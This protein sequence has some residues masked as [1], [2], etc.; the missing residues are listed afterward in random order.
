MS[1]RQL[2]LPPVNA[3]VVFEAAAR[4]LSFTA[5]AA[6]LGVSQAAVS[7]QIRA[8]ED[9][10]GVALFR[11][12]HRAV[13]LT[14]EGERLFGAVTMGLG[15]ISETAAALR[16]DQGR[17]QITV[18]T[19]IAFAAFWLMPRIDRFKS[20]HPDLEL[21]FIAS[22]T[23]VD[24]RAEGIDIAVR[25]GAG[26]WPGLDAYRLFDEEVFP[27]CNPA[28]LEGGPR[29]DE[30]GDLLDATLLHQ[31]AGEPSWLTWRDWL[32][33]QDVTPPVKIPG[34]RFNN[35]TILMQAAQAGQ[36]VALGW[37]RLIEPLVAAGSLVRPIEAS[38]AAPDAY[39][40]VMPEQSG[41][42]EAAR[43]LRDWLHA[44]AEGER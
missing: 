27:V 43:A 33:S 38:L 40:T 35:Y 28:Y 10:L 13:R 6:E 36:G 22:D 41:P 30:T 23:A 29:L 20:A 15:H 37:R 16:R 19:T 8:L 17:H 39:Y 3:L 24:P 14:A 12:L 5:A 18:C 9:H 25:Y 21:R 42:S 7:R 32:K 11:R 2:P 44:E 31:E 1:K 34:P 26:R 4:R